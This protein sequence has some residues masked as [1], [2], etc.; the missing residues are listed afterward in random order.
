M[1]LAIATAL[2]LLACA[3]TARADAVADVDKLAWM[4]GTWREVDGATT[5]RETWL[6]PLDGAMS[7]VGQTSKTGKPATFEFMSITAEPAGATFTAR[8]KGQNPTPF[9]LQPGPD[10]EAVFEN[11]AHNFPQRVI[12]RRCGIQLCGA[13]EG[14]K[15]G[16]T[17]TINWRYDRVTR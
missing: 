6:A 8:L 1:R 16:K 5:T 7:G 3:T 2:A 14:V 13:I 10:G 15:A 11:L 9:V 4:A 12:Y 17:I